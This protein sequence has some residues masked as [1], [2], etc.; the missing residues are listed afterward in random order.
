VDPLGN[1]YI[2]DSFNLKIRRVSPGGVISAFAGNGNF[3]F[4]GDGGPATAA[5]MNEPSEVAF[6]QKGSIYISDT[7]N[8]RIR[9]I[10][11]SGIITTIAGTGIAGF[12]GDGG[13][14]TAAMLNTP[15]GLAF[16]AA[17]NLYVGDALNNR[18][19]KIDTN[20]I[21]TTFAGA[22]GTISNAAHLV[23]DRTGNLYV[24]TQ[25]NIFKIT[26][27]G[28]GSTYAGTGLQEPVGDGGPPS[29]AG[30]DYMSG[31]AFDSKQNLYISEIYR[32][33][34][35][36][37]TSA[38][39]I[40]RTFAGNT[41]ECCGGDGGQA[42]QAGIDADSIALDSSDVLYIGGADRIRRVGSDGVISTIAGTAFPDDGIGDGGSA[43]SASLR[44]VTGLGVDS[45]GTLYIVDSGHGRLR[46]VLNV[47]PRFDVSPLTLTF[48]GISGGPP[49]VDQF[50]RVSSA[51]SNLAYK[52]SVNT[53]NGDWL[54][55]QPAIGITPGTIQISAIPAILAPG[56]YNGTVTI[57]AP[58]SN[59]S[60]RVI[61]VRINV[62]PASA[63]KLVAQPDDLAFDFVSGLPPDT[64][65]L[66]VR[67][68]GAGTIRFD[69]VR[70]TTNGGD[71]LKLSASTGSATATS[72]VSIQVTADPGKLAV[73]TYSGLVTITSGALRSFVPVVMTIHSTAQTILVPEQGLTFQAASGSAIQKDIIEVLNTG[74]GNLNWTASTQVLSGPPG[75]L[76]VT[77]TSGASGAGKSTAV[78]V[79]VSADP[80]KLSPGDYYGQ[81]LIASPE[82][83]NSPHVLS[84]V[85]HVGEANGAAD[86]DIRPTGSIFV[87]FPG[88]PPAAQDF[89]ISNL[90]GVSTAYRSTGT[91]DSGPAF[92]T[93]QP[94]E[95]TVDPAQPVRLTIQPTAARLDPGIKRGRVTLQFTDGSIRVIEVVLVVPAIAG[96]TEP[97]VRGADGCTPTKLAVVFSLLGQQFQVFA[98]WPKPIE[99]RI[100]DDCGTPLT[101]G[102]V[103]VS[104]SN[105]DASVSLQSLGGGRWSGTWQPGISARQV[106]ATAIAQNAAGPLKGS[107]Q[108]AG[109]VDP[110]PLVPVIAP[111]SVLNAASLTARTPVTP[112]GLISIFGTSL[113]SEATLS[114][115]P[116]RTLLNGTLAVMGGVSLPLLYVSPTQ[117]NAIVPT[118]IPINT[119][120]QLYVLNRNSSTLPIAVSI[121]P[122]Q[123]AVFSVDGSGSGQGH[124]YSAANVLADDAHPVKAGEV[125]VIY[126]AGLGKVDQEV[127][128]GFPAPT[129]PLARVIDPVTVTVGGKPANVLFA[130][131]APGFTGL[132]QINAVI[133]D[134]LGASGMAEVI[135]KVSDQTS[136]VVTIGVR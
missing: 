135:L 130:G 18:V 44:N 56:S 118:K 114:E 120:Q 83:T 82:A 128:D 113:S 90:G 70:S 88:T 14:A 55:A 59:P 126:C 41:S 75:W 30:F 92:F 107:T 35:R 71:W 48:E 68:N 7:R 33:R 64:Q 63:P 22:N 105:G 123:P 32:G 79:E 21:I 78:Q 23:F 81:V 6:D 37:I 20:G 127:Q 9:K 117:I 72:P 34:V 47:P 46:A 52:V 8:Q 96:S 12:S 108:A 112:G 49:A 110:N 115:V 84:V 89:V 39:G 116:R 134:G 26:P 2:A 4:G 119:N 60:R 95:A 40:I 66:L 57:D 25:F 50:L 61:S 85:F 43:L 102:S 87:A 69:A 136:P 13:K 17:G 10:D 31:L 19:R 36:R 80:S 91:S 103:V 38:D 98:A 53:T 121:A 42:L 45:A 125:V 93:Y 54:I 16:D 67:N 5:L 65:T 77:P 132:Y 106:S 94:T 3:K 24:S 124:I 129:S 27:G 73:G 97:A 11:A 28:A 1:V 76:S 100:T 99:T 133:P 109:S 58:Q 122:A 131:L 51:I 86:P 111:G 74:L 15:I 101:D 104:F 29:Q 62:A